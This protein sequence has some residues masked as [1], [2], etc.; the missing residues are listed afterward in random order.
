MTDRYA[1]AGVDVA[2]ADKGISRIV[3]NIKSTWPKEAGVGQVNLDIGYFANVINIGGGKGLATTMDGVGSK[4]IIAEMMEDYSTIG[5]DCVAMNVNDLICVGA[6]PISMLDYIGVEYANAETLEE[7][8]VGLAAGAIEAGISISGGEISQLPDIITGFDLVGSAFGLVDLDRMILGADLRPG[9][10]IV[11]LSSTGIHSN[12]LTLAR[13]V[14]FDE[15]QLDPFEDYGL[16]R[17][18]GDE[19]LTPTAIY[20]PEVMKM[21]ENLPVKALINITGD[22]L[23][24]LN[25]VQTKD[26]GFHIDY[27]PEPARIFDLI[28]QTGNID[29]STMFQTFNMGV[30]FCVIVAPDYAEDVISI[31]HEFDEDAFELGLVVKDEFKSV[32]LPTKRIVGRGKHFHQI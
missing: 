20:V 21:I 30:G 18:L 28:Q 19:L 10:V 23:L 14:L 13:K 32:Y 15:G 1:L 24:N 9:D 3:K 6:R 5:V 2:E 29:Q 26:V 11:G 7:I 17:V 4:T 25:R 31:A 16:D 8:S 22:G 27:L 12:G